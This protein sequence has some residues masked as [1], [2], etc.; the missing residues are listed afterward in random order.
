MFSTKKEQVVT[1]RPYTNE[2]TKLMFVST[3]DRNYVL[4]RAA[5]FDELDLDFYWL[6]LHALEKYYKAVLLMN[7]E[8]AKGYSHDL[9]KLHAAVIKLDPRLPIGPLVDPRIEDLHWHDEPVEKYLERLNEYGSADNRYATYGYSL[10]LEDLFKVDQLV[11]SVRRCCRPLRLKVGRS[12]G[13]ETEIDYVDQLIRNARLWTLGGL[14][15][16]EKLLARPNDDARGA[17]FL[18][19]NTPFAPDAV[20]VVA[21]WRSSASNPPL[22][23]WFMR[24]NAPD[25]APDE[26][27]TAAEVLSWA[28]DH[29]KFNGKDEKEIR[30][31]LTAY[32]ASL[33][34]PADAGCA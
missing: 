14:M 3:A 26:R 30:A 27:Q 2:I 31:A 17:A 9:L 20:H 15:P 10:R 22:A 23:D 7:G 28:I 32:A 16:L 33:E 18:Y 34:T 11:W 25:A 5:F 24:L 19:L 4:A 8:K 13:G 29:I 21:S 6:S 1:T 12:D